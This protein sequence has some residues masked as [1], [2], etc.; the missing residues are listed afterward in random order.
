MLMGNDDLGRLDR[1]AVLIAHGHLALRV[2][3][4]RL[5]DARVAGDGNL[6]K[7]LVGIVQ[8]RRHQFRR[9]AAG[10]AEHDALVPRPLVLVACGVDALSDIGRLRVQQHLDLRITPVK[11]FLLV[12]DVLDGLP[13]GLDDLVV[14]NGRAA[15]FAGDDHPVG[16][17][18][19]LAGDADLVGIDAGLRALAEEEIDDFVRNPVAHLV[20]VA[21]RN[22]FAGELVIQTR[23]IDDLLQTHFRRGCKLRRR[24][25]SDS[26]RSIRQAILRE[27]VRFIERLRRSQ[28]RRPRRAAQAIRRDR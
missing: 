13:D 21:F 5:L 7:D 20:G 4:E 3:A 1:L 11:A 17:C 2:R 19:R 25:A 12:A 28:A 15:D 16:G 18:K 8:R 14:R 10:V 6:P 23:H 26:D 22:R 27:I 9:L 24:G